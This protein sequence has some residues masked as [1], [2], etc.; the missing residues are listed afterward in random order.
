MSQPLHILFQATKASDEYSP[1]L[2]P[3][4]VVHIKGFAS[5]MDPLL[6][7]HSFLNHILEDCHEIMWDG[8]ALQPGS[9]TTLVPALV[10]HLVDGDSDLPSFNA[11]CYANNEEFFKSKWDDIVVT[12]PDPTDNGRMEI[13]P[14]SETNIDINDMRTVTVTYRCV[15]EDVKT[16]ESSD[17][18]IN[19]PN[20]YLNLGLHAI[21]TTGSLRVYTV[22]GGE[23]V[24]KEYLASMERDLKPKWYIYNTSRN[25]QINGNTVEESC[26]ILRVSP[27][28][29]HGTGT[30]EVIEP[31][32]KK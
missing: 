7:D 17:T 31:T 26:G 23:C 4:Q 11:F 13:R 25:V 27:A 21:R 28:G 3:N 2:A 15:N 19:S 30:Y 10:N 22:G 9:F 14:L 6:F 16:S 12:I 29:G 24:E 5:K 32:W 1:S 20:I 8:D 18:G